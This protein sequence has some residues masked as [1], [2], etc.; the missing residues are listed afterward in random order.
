VY[1]TVAVGDEHITIATGL[2]ALRRLLPPEEVVP[3]L[4]V[5]EEIDA[6]QQRHAR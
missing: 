3:T 5:S 1:A 4:D 6:Y 2:P